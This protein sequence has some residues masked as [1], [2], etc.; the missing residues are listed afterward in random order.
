ML[1]CPWVILATPSLPEASWELYRFIPPAGAGAQLQQLS[2][3]LVGGKACGSH[4]IN[5]QYSLCFMQACKVRFSYLEETPHVCLRDYKMREAANSSTWWQTTSQHSSCLFAI[6][7]FA[8]MTGMWK[9]PKE[10]WPMQTSLPLASFSH[11]LLLLSYL[12]WCNFWNGTICYGC[13]LMYILRNNSIWKTE[14]YW[15]YMVSFWR[16]RGSDNHVSPLRSSCHS[17]LFF[18]SHTLVRV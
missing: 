12:L 7:A 6:C 11:C 5:V 2:Q 16:L 3:P 10:T 1:P 13:N 9:T 17:A 4:R 14:V 15:A 18:L 8:A